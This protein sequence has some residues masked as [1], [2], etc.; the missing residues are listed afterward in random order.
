MILPRGGGRVRG[1]RGRVTTTNLTPIQLRGRA[2]KTAAWKKKKKKILSEKKLLREEKNSY[3]YS[4]VATRVKKKKKNP[5][6]CDDVYERA[7]GA[8]TAAFTDC[9]GLL[10]DRPTTRAN[11]IAVSTRGLRDSPA[12]TTTVAATTTL[13]R[14][15]RRAHAAG[16]LFCVP[17]HAVGRPRGAFLFLFLFFFF[18]PPPPPPPY[19]LY[20][21]IFVP[22]FRRRWTGQPT[23][24]IAVATVNAS[25]RAPRIDPSRALC[26]PDRSFVPSTRATAAAMRRTTRRASAGFRWILNFSRERFAARVE[27]ETGPK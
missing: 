3:N 5:R 7:R 18:P 22:P 4:N 26:R 21:F 10:T 27:I 14:L 15:P 8:S 2:L 19:R 17:P 20:L 1:E 12:P 13:R 16:V 24:R 9:S 6:R 23:R 25:A 11:D